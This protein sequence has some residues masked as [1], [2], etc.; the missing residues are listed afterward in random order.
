MLT[1]ALGEQQLDAQVETV[2]VT[3][4]RHFEALTRA[5]EALTQG[6]AMLE[7]NAPPE[8]VVEHTREALSA[9]GTITGETFTE[10]V[11]DSVFRAS[12]SANS[13]ARLCR[14]L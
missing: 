7:Q 5:T 10:D 13:V 11:L 3:Q 2:Q 4:R 14:R 1:T 6:L 9:L 12:A 8:V